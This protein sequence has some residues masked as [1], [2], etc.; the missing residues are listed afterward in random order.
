MTRNQIEYWNYIEQARANRAK[1]AEDARS[2]RAQENENYRSHRAQEELSYQQQQLQDRNNSLNRAEQTR[3]NIA[4]E[5]ENTR[6][7]LANEQINMQRNMLTTSAQSEIARSNLANEGI[8][9]LN[10]LNSM[11]KTSNESRQ[12][13]NSYVLGML[14]N[15]NTRRGQDL[16]YIINK[17]HAEN[18]AR[19]N[20]LLDKQT[21][22]N[23]TLQRERNELTNKQ[24][25]LG[26]Q[27]LQET[28]QHNRTQEYIGAFGT[29]LKAG[30]SIGRRVS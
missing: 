1:E 17:Q 30:L 4:R 23:A 12:I 21:Y 16:S 7:N 2:H 29:A 19:R 6:S 27:N 13:S 3:S 11:Q 22:L 10:T 28:I 25:E 14:N 20:V 9:R 26:Q 8:A 15:T 18:E 24:I 5:L